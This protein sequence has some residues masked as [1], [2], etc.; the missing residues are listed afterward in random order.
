MVAGI[1]QLTDR[2][3]WLL[4]GALIHAVAAVLWAVIAVLVGGGPG[5]TVA[6][7]GFVAGAITLVVARSWNRTTPSASPRLVRRF[8][9]VFAVEGALIGVTSGAALVTD[10]QRWIPV[11][12]AFIVGGH[13]IPTD[14]LFGTRYDYPLGALLVLGAVM[15]PLLVVSHDG[16]EWAVVIGAIAAV[17]LLAASLARLIDASRHLANGADQ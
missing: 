5:T 6:A 11:L 16:T 14:A 10:N 7:A 15:T 2:A 9:I 4:T 13:L 17:V 8:G 1:R 3:R 12:V